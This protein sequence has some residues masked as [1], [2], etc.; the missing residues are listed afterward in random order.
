MQH[1]LN[2]FVGPSPR[3][4][5]SLFSLSISTDELISAPKV[6]AFFLMVPSVNENSEQELNPMP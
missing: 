6:M 3:I 4:K 2:P 5:I 1:N